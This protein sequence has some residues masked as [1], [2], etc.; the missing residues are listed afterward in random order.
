M[1]DAARPEWAP[2]SVNLQVPSAAR[3]WDYFLGGSHNFAVDREVAEAAIAMKPDM[4]QLAKAV[5]IYLRRATEAIAQAGVTQ[6]LDIGSGIPTVGSVHEVA[7]EVNPDAR[8]VYVDHDP[9]AVAHSQK[10][11]RDYDGVVAVRGDVRAP[12][13]ILADAQVRDTLDFSRPIGLLLCALLHFVSDEADPGGLVGTLR[14]ALVPGSFLAVQHATNDEQPPETI[15]ML[16]MWNA[17]SPEPM[18]WRT[19]EEITDLFAGFTLLEPGVVFLSQWRPEPWEESDP[20][21]ERFASYAA[22]GRKN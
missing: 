6:F 4:P 18:Y 5:R 9:V 22:L 3:V 12:D 7:R 17:N 10:L 16:K 15:E 13:E 20:H 2:E 8:V 14:D 19:R 1:A 21:P 11:L